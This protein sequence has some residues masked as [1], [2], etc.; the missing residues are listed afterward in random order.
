MYA[1]DQ[2]ANPSY[3]VTLDGK[4]QVLQEQ[5][6]LPDDRTWHHQTAKLLVP[7]GTD[8]LDVTVSGSSSGGAVCLDDMQVEILSPE[9]IEAVDLSYQSIFTDGTWRF[10][11][12]EGQTLAHQFYRVPALLDGEEGYIVAEKV[13]DLI[14]VYPDFFLS[15]IHI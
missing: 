13:S 7:V 6:S 9:A 14:C 15:L 1:P 11:L 5:L 12:A 2:T 3:C 4:S 8:S 10:T